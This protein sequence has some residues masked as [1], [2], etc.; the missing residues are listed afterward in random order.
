MSKDRNKIVVDGS[1]DTDRLTESD[2]QRYW[3]GEPD[4]HMMRTVFGE[5]GFTPDPKNWHAVGEGK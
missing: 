2:Y 5:A 3:H 1:L 4:S